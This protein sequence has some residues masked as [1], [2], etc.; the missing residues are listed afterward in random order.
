[1]EGRFEMSINTTVKFDVITAF[2]ENYLGVEYDPDSKHLFTPDGNNVLRLR[3]IKLFPAA[4]VL[5]EPRLEEFVHDVVTRWRPARE[6]QPYWINKLLDYQ[7]MAPNFVTYDRHRPNKVNRMHI[8]AGINLKLRLSI[9]QHGRL[10]GALW[11]PRYT[12]LVKA[13]QGE[14]IDLGRFTIETEMPVSVHVIDSSG[15]PL[16]G[17]PVIHGPA[18]HITDADGIAPFWVPPRY[19]GE[20]TVSVRTE[21][22]DRIGQSIAYETNGPEDA[23]NVYTLQ[24]SD[25]M[26]EALFK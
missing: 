8:P 9:I 23:N 24:L 12:G 7:N 19:K 10:G 13:N 11:C 21:N 20:F 17:V 2:A 22:R 25:E 16:E 1:M 4:T 6:D 5:I 14:T 26:L 15:R 3:T 18:Q